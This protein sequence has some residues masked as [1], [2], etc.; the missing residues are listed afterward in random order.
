MTELR[1]AEAV[2][3][4]RRA[5]VMTELWRA[6]VVVAERRATVMTELRRAKAVVAERRATVM[7]E[8]WRAKAMVAMV[9]KFTMSVLGLTAPLVSLTVMMS[10]AVMFAAT[11]MNCIAWSVMAWLSVLVM[12]ATVC[13][14]TLMMAMAR[15]A[16]SG[17]FAFGAGMTIA[18]ATSV[19]ACRVMPVTIAT[20]I[21]API[22][23]VPVTVA[24]FSI[25]ASHFTTFPVTLRVCRGA[26]T[27][28]HALAHFVKLFGLFR[29]HNFLDDLAHLV[30]VGSFAVFARLFV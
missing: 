18:R 1:R 14:V 22:M 27:L 17:P 8:L 6:K 15:L 9:S 21:V 24:S 16:Q 26:H 11:S 5:T 23:R 30:R 29:A 13:Q 10:A 12:T 25:A 28:F 19:I 20:F 4:E 7:T 3:A 2:V